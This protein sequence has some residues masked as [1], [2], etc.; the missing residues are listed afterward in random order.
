MDIPGRVFLD[1][2]VVNFTLDW[3]EAIFD[4]GEIPDYLPA[5]VG[6]DI[7]A[8]RDIFLTGQRASWQLAISPQT[9]NEIQ[10]T[11]DPERRAALERWFGE[12]WFYWRKFFEQDDLSDLDA[13]SLAKRLV[14]AQFLAA[15]PQSSDREL[16][17]YAVAYGCDAFCTRDRK[18]I[19]R[20]RHELNGLPLRIFTPA[21][22]WAAIAPYAGLWV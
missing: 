8:L 5:Q 18:T 16:I 14:P 17:A 13:E 4:G 1:T 6:A 3:G 22:W 7:L 19:L 2:N 21:E 10:A 9:Y 11:S 15:F 12:L 20:H